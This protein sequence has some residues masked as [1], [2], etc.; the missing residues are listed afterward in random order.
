MHTYS[1]NEPK[2]S[3]IRS[4]AENCGNYFLGVYKGFGL[5][6]VEL[7]LYG[8]PITVDFYYGAMQFLWRVSRNRR[9]GIRTFGIVLICDNSQRHS[10]LAI[11]L[12]LDQ[13]KRDIFE[14]PTYSLGLVPT[15]LILLAFL[16]L[17]VN[18]WIDLWA[19]SSNTSSQIRYGPKFKFWRRVFA[20]L[21]DC[22]D[23]WR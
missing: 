5:L 16:F 2:C 9:R 23:V 19:W 3:K 11:Q 8:T 6:L 22:P 12:I 10:F 7:M 21:R 20:T 18:M 15:N 13:F 14:H 4:A 1:S 17:V